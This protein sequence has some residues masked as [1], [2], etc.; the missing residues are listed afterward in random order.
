VVP[1]I[2][3]EV[4]RAVVDIMGEAQVDLAM[5]V[6]RQEAVVPDILEAV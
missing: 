4:V 2:K 5:E 3:V 1:R 6:L